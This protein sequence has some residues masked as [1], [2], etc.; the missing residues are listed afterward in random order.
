L[1]ALARAFTPVL[2]GV[3]FWRY[4]STSVFVGGA[5]LAFFAFVLGGRLP[6]PVK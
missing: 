2:A 6:K 4:G 5:V 1:S 3:V